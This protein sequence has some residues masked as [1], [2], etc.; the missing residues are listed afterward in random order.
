[1]EHLMFLRSAQFPSRGILVALTALGVLWGP[2]QTDGGDISFAAKGYAFPPSCRHIL[3]LHLDEDANVDLLVAA[4]DGV[5]VLLGM[6]GGRFTLLQSLPTPSF[7]L[8]LATGDLDGDDRLDIVSANEADQSISVFRGRE[9][10]TFEPWATLRL[11]GHPLSVAVGDIDSDG[12]QDLM[13]AIGT[14]HSVTLFNNNNDGTFT[15]SYARTSH[16]FTS[17][18]LVDLNNDG[19][20]DCL[21][22]GR[23]ITVHLGDGRG[24]FRET[25]F[26]EN[27]GNVN[28]KGVLV[29]DVNGDGWKDLVTAG[30]DG[31]VVRTGGPGGRLGPGTQL[32]MDR[33]SS[34]VSGDFNADSYL[35]FAAATTWW[36]Y[37]L[38]VWLGSEDGAF[39]PGGQLDGALFEWITT[40]DVDGDGFLDLA[41]PG[42]FSPE[43]SAASTWV[44]IL[45]GSGDGE[46][47][48]DYQD[49]RP[50]GIWDAELG[51]LNGDPW[52]DLVLL[53]SA[54]GLS[55]LP[56]LLGASFAGPSFSEPLSCDMLYA[57]NE[58]PRALAVGDLDGDGWTD[59]VTSIPQVW[60][61]GPES[62]PFAC[63]TVAVHL[64]HGDGS[65]ATSTAMASEPRPYRTLL[66]DV[67]S[68]A[69]LDLIN[70]ADYTV[71]SI[72]LGSGDGT[73]RQASQVRVA[74]SPVTQ[75]AVEELNGD[76]KADLLVLCDS[77]VTLLGDGRGSFAGPKSAAVAPLPTQFVLGD[78]NG[79]RIPD[80]VVT[81]LASTRVYWGIGD[82]SFGPGPIV[83]EHT[84][85]G[86]LLADLDGD[87][88]LDIVLAASRGVPLL[89]VR[90]G[91]GDGSFEPGMGYLIG[92][93]T[94]RLL[95]RDLDGDDRVDLV[96]VNECGIS[97]L[98]STSLPTELSVEDLLVVSTTTGVRVTWRLGSAA[99][100]A[101]RGILVEAAESPQGPFASRVSTALVPAAFMSFDDSE[102]EPGQERWYRLALLGRDGSVQ[103]THALSIRREN[104]GFAP[105][106]LSP[107]FEV[108][109][110]SVVIRY[111][112]QPPG[113]LVLLSVYDVA[114]RCLWST[115]LANHDAGDFVR[116]WDRSLSSGA[117]ASRGVYVLRL[118]TPTASV[119]R[120]FVLVRP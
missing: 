65:F 45:I 42:A 1:M 75:L 60:V 53:D 9:D 93:N 44:T 107:P 115:G 37:K 35:D 74:R 72:A 4:E 55:V 48:G 98:R 27:D 76:G 56:G 22:I 85:G 52:P 2:Q 111:S 18:Q 64:A 12:D 23:G 84:V 32:A 28:A 77:L 118:K 78:L 100:R 108:E 94:R 104:R 68:D 92:E 95:A 82:G 50:C 114:G 73:F 15:P 102:L 113:G 14:V 6:G 109:G 120:K 116:G 71:V 3:P 30:L 51:T 43:G 33:Y 7:P 19:F 25:Q 81:A 46:F 39:R 110:G 63:R 58:T 90:R 49:E 38:R 41:L 87:A 69:R 57:N 103:H 101:L 112:V 59:A 91:R 106:A 117:R 20:L 119:A 34:V 97:I 79:D 36:P 13:V 24:G 105:T 31:L 61:P 86:V 29:V 89:T 16:V 21:R 26:V 66:A 96:A 88:I 67:D 10:A 80:A 17:V 11:F 70:A 8:T 40:A 83:A 62:P 47:G 99:L 54:R 5:S